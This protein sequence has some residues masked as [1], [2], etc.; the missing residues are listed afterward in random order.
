MSIRKW[1]KRKPHKGDSFA[2]ILDILVIVSASF[3][4][5]MIYSYL[6]QFNRIYFSSFALGGMM[7]LAFLALAIFYLV[8]LLQQLLVLPN[9]FLI[10][11]LLLLL[12]VLVP[13]DY[14]G[15]FPGRRIREF[16]EQDHRYMTDLT[17]GIEYEILRFTNKERE[18]R[19]LSHLLWDEDLAKIARH[20]S[21]DMAKNEFFSHVNPDYEDPTT[22]AREAG[23]TTH[24]LIIEWFS[25][26]IAENIGIMPIGHVK[27]VGYVDEVPDSIAAAQVYAW[28]RSANHSRNILDPE[29]TRMGAGVAVKDRRYTITQDIY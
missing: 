6:D 15:L 25:G 24:E 7:F 27:D 13:Q 22:R 20:H 10:S 11:M 16:T 3:S 9:Y 28:M 29:A 5:L 17:E 18:L 4:A 19:N 1:M 14:S 21:L 26:S 12:L 2:V 8:I 23:Y